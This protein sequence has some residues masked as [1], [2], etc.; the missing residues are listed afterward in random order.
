MDPEFILDLD[1]IEAAAKAATPQDLDSAEDKSVGGWIECLACGGEGSVE[2]IAD[3]LNYDGEAVGVQFYGV[4]DAHV[5]AEAFLRA[6]KPAVVLNMVRQLRRLREYAD[7]IAKMQE[8]L[9]IAQQLADANI[10]TVKVNP[11]D[12]LL[13][14]TKASCTPATHDQFAELS[15]NL[16]RHFPEG[17]PVILTNDVDISA[18]DAEAM[19]QAGWVKA[20]PGGA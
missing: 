15:R 18:L 5:N 3:Y 7:A 2:V 1:A 14:S 12:V 13:I 17:T 16:G 9:R 20:E 11:G 19:R 8:N 4:G 6:A 10:S